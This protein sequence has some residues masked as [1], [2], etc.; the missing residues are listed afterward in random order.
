MLKLFKKRC[1]EFLQDRLY[2]SYLY[3]FAYGLDASCY[4]YIP[5]L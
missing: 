5:K 3:R 2:D 1:Q 4:R